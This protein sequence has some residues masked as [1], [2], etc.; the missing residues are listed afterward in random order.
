MGTSA[1]IAVDIFRKTTD[2]QKIDAEFNNS[3]FDNIF[4]INQEG[5]LREAKTV[6]FDKDKWE[7][8]PQQFCLDHYNDVSF[9][10]IVMMVNNIGSIFEFKRDN[11]KDNKIRVPIVNEIYNILA[12][13]NF[14]R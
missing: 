2:H 6:I 10:R 11:F 9:Y 1:N 7:Y 5:L 3:I 8:N 13:A 4:W 14:K 12:Y